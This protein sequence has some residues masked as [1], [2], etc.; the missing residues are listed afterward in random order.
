SEDEFFIGGFEAND[1]GFAGAVD[2][3]Q[4]FNYTLQ[5]KDVANIFWDS[6]PV[7]DMRFD[8]PPARTIFADRSFSAFEGSCAGDACPL[9]GIQGREMQ[10]VHFDGVDDVIVLTA[11]AQ[12][13]E[14][15]QSSFTL[16][17]WAYVDGAGSHT[18]FGSNGPGSEYLSLG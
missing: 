12:D 11:N 14:L 3:L 5:P 2:E 8:E 10:A 15:S 1:D 17:T 4:I 7:L 13:L 16:A 9:S 18:A 6:Q